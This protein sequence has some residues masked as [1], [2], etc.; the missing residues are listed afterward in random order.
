MLGLLR[1]LFTKRR[2]R[3]TRR[4]VAPARVAMRGRK[5]FAIAEHLK[6]FNGYPIVDW[7]EVTAWASGFKP[8]RRRAKAWTACERAWLLHFRDA[9]GPDFRL[10]ESQTAF[11]LSSLQPNVATAALEFMRRAPRRIALILEELAQARPW[12]KE[13]LIVF[14][15]S[16]AYYRYASYYYPEKGEFALSGGMHIDSGCSHYVSP[17]ND[18]AQIEP[19]VA[20]EMTHGCLGHLP[21]PL[22]LNEGLAVNTE[23][24]VTGVRYSTPT[25]DE[26]HALHCRFWSA[27]RIQQFWSGKSFD[28]QDEGNKLSYDLARIIVE[29]LARDWA[30]FKRFVLR[31]NGADSGAAAAR[32]CLGL[33]LGDVVLSL[34]ERKSSRSWSPNPLAW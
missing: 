33:D 17:R 28:R 21:L 4:E 12:G 27:G 13:I 22:W 8:A 29:Q 18:L 1:S 6:R 10:E 25:P 2:L 20:H 14:A 30:S 11:L 34:L 15:D 32:N 24:R 16:E 5:P 3:S 7:D 9:L 26:L 31:S 23:R 19:M